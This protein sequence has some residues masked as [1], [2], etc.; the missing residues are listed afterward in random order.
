MCELY[1]MCNINDESY[2]ESD[3]KDEC[4]DTALITLGKICAKFQTNCY[5]CRNI[6]H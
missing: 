1:R 4:K 5:N 3:I 2:E 6:G